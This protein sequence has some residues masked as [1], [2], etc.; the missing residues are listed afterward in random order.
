MF[1]AQSLWPL[2]E[3]AS[4]EITEF[5][6]PAAQNSLHQADFGLVTL[7]LPPDSLSIDQAFD[8]NETS[9]A[10]EPRKRQRLALKPAVLKL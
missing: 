1:G 7:P 3:D 4:V 6:L 9:V 10:G 8:L 2:S 5:S